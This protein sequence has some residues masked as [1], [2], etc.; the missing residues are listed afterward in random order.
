MKHLF[1]S[2]SIGFHVN[3]V[4]R[5]QIPDHSLVTKCDYIIVI[6]SLFKK[7]THYDFYPLKALYLSK[8]VLETG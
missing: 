3:L 6:C 4:I 7:P 1:A 5:T 8:D 2:Q